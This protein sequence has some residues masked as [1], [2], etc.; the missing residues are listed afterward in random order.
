MNRI[1]WITI[2]IGVGFAALAII[3]I[4]NWLITRFTK[5]GARERNTMEPRDGG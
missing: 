3:R 5:V 1:E 4:A 2:I